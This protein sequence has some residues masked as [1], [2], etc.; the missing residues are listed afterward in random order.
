MINGPIN[1][2]PDRKTL[3]EFSELWLF[4]VGMIASPLALLRGHQA[5]AAAFWILAVGVRGLGL[6]R[7]AWVRPFFVGLTLAGWPI[8]WVMSHLALALVYYLVITPVGL[9]FRLIG[10][11]PLRRALDR[12]AV[13]YWERYNPNR[14]ADRYLRQF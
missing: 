8:G 14:G 4:F 6:W 1:W 9:T 5:W 12:Q 2:N 3:V 13:T 7:P 11:D 10:R